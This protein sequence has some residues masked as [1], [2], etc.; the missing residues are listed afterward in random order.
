MV[1]SMAN[2]QTQKDYHTIVIGAGIGGLVSA[3]KLA[4]EGKRILVIEQHSTPGG[5][6]TTFKR[7]QF[8][9]E[10]GL[11]AVDGMYNSSNPNLDILHELDIT[12]KLSFIRLPE[13]FHVSHGDFSLTLAD[14]MSSAKNHLFRKFPREKTAITKYMKLLK[15]M[16]KEILNFPSDRKDILPL[17]PLLPFLFPTILRH[18]F[19]SLGSFMQRLTKNEELKL[20]L[21]ANTAYYH[22][23]PHKYS[24]LH[25]GGAQ[26][27][28]LDG[29]C[30]YIQGGSSKLAEHL[31]NYIQERNGKLLF[32]H[33]VNSIIFSGNRVHGVTC[34]PADGHNGTASKTFT[35]NFII[36]NANIPS[37]INSLLPAEKGKKLRKKYNNYVLSHSGFCL[38]LGLKKPLSTIGNKYFS[39]FVLP[40]ELTSLR[41]IVAHNNTNDF[42]KK[43]LI[44]VDYSLIPA[45]LSKNNE[46]TA[47]VMVVDN[48]DN[49]ESMSP[50]AYKIKKERSCRILI[51][52]LAKYLPGSNDL[53]EYYEAGTP[54][55][56]A[57]F[58]GNPR[59]SIYGYAQNIRQV[60]PNRPNIY[61]SI[62]GI[63][64]A[65]AWTK[66]GGGISPV[67]KSGYNAA[68]KILKA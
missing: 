53:I 34:I 55:T 43:I 4:K 52:R 42:T 50:E 65:S 54:K 28:Y 25:Y 22:T 36:A 51:D 66:P 49:W 33:R 59:G 13:F 38:Y 60:G 41:Q 40:D 46:P 35:S 57:R 1:Q 12:A 5:Y 2:T 45:N 9:F 61:S 64:F 44:V 27:T 16:R 23:D 7:K 24:L 6:A 68:I 17:I 39:S 29:G 21:C 58:T 3:A 67:I 11:H 47:T 26:S 30:A 14:D 20:A 37:V 31:V 19:S 48:I 62:P 15:K 63:Y 18:I 8:V 56:M 10:A 32:N